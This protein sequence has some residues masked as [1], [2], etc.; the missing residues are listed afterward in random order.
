MF[1]YQVFNVS[2]SISVSV[3]GVSMGNEITG[4][5]HWCAKCDFSTARA[6]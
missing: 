5:K 6:I 3:P 1:I 4:Q 2:H